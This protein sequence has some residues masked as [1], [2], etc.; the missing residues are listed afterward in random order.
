MIAGNKICSLTCLNPYV[1]KQRTN[2]YGL[3][4]CDCG[5][6]KLIRNSAIAPYQTESCGC[7]RTRHEGLTSNPLWDTW[8]GMHARCY[9]PKHHAY[10]NYGARGIKV[11]ERWH[12]LKYFI[13]DLGQRPDGLEMDRIDNNKDYGPDN[14]HWVTRTDN[15]NNRRVTRLLTYKGETKPIQIWAKLLNI[16]AGSL[17]NRIDTNGWSIE[18][19]FETPVRK[20]KAKVF[21]KNAEEM[22]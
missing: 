21:S 22:Y 16:R 19:A 10:R 13:E 5:V 11:C 3:W 1:E 4:K 6:E 12:T 9:N 18:Q 17:Y 20:R 2:W 7:K 15:L 14:F 8:K